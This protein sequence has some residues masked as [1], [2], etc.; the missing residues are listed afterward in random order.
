[1][2][3]TNELAE[4]IF[5]VSKRSWVESSNQTSAITE[6]EFL[7]LEYL[8]EVG[9]TSVGEIQHHIN[10]VPAQMS[11]LLRRLEAEMLVTTAINP[12][13]RRKV[14]VT[15]SDTG[16]AIR[17]EYRKAKLAPIVSALDRL[18][19]EERTEFMNLVKKMTGA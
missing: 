8:C 3:H 5:T 19:S 11:R 9:T 2:P 4:A 13:D 16:R 1:M 14:D 7:A 6:S 18:T 17:D 12:N 15:I 10:V